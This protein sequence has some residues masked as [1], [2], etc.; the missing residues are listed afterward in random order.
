[1]KNET[2]TD[3]YERGTPLLAL[4][5][6]QKD[7]VGENLFDLSAVSRGNSYAMCKHSKTKASET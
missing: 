2:K 7:F 1:M 6:E 4:K 5:K 3:K